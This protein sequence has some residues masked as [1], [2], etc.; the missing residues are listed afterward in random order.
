M[1]I[2]HYTSSWPPSL[3]LK[4]KR[5]ENLF[6]RF[7]EVNRN[8]ETEIAKIRSKYSIPKNGFSYLREGEIGLGIPKYLDF[9]LYDRYLEDEFNLIEKFGFVGSWGLSLSYFIKYN[10]MPK[11]A[12][13]IIPRASVFDGEVTLL[14]LQ[15]D[16]PSFLK[17]RVL[18]S[19]SYNLNRK[20]FDDIIT[21]QWSQ[22]KEQLKTLPSWRSL[23]RKSENIKL[24]KEIDFLINKLGN[25]ADV[26]TAIF[27]KH[28]KNKNL[29]DE[30]Y[31]RNIYSRYKKRLS[32]T[33]LK[34][35]PHS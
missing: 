14:Q 9:D 26:S 1:K 18:I 2:R 23:K 21:N 34:S 25:W 32:D 19:F 5:E 30:T 7:L 6:F 15:N 24:F 20:Q 27:D 3:K 22:I 17:R 8:F 16:Y 33:S 35:A 4:L 31:V 29:A 13:E 10:L 28:P 12:E 11:M